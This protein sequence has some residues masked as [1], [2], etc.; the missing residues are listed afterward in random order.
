MLRSTC[1]KLPQLFEKLPA[2]I[3]DRS[4]APNRAIPFART[5][6]PSTWAIR[7]AKFGPRTPQNWL[8]PS[9]ATPKSPVRFEG[10][11]KN[12][13]DERPAT[14][15]TRRK[16]PRIRRQPPAPSPQPLNLTAVGQSSHHVH[17]WSCGWPMPTGW[18]ARP[19]DPIGSTCP[20]GRVR[21]CPTRRRRLRSTTGAPRRSAR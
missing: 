10:V 3:R 1:T 12:L 18:A 17:D 7:K 2:S 19:R 15:V 14:G 8:S 5:R 20:P 16:P 21:A 4:R 13:D 11:T 9:K 6:P